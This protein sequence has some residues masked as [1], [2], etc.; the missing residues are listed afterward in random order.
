VLVHL[1]YGVLRLLRE[2][3]CLVSMLR[4][5]EA[6]YLRHAQCSH[7]NRHQSVYKID[8]S[9]RQEQRLDSYLIFSMFKVHFTLQYSLVTTMSVTTLSVTKRYLDIMMSVTKMLAT[10][11]Y[12]VITMPGIYPGLGALPWY[13]NGYYDSPDTLI[14]FDIPRVS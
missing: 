8:Y 1:T 7:L 10:T 14:Y 3:Y 9:T 11:I 4:L 6:V 2:I 5:T 13:V 12:L